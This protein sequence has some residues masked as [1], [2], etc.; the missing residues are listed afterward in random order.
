MRR[1]GQP[2]PHTL[3]WVGGNSPP[4][5]GSMWTPSPGHLASSSGLSYLTRSG[6]W[7]PWP[8]PLPDHFLSKSSLESWDVTL[9][10]MLSHLLSFMVTLF[11]QFFL[12]F[13]KCIII[14]F[15]NYLLILWLTVVSIINIIYFIVFIIIIYNVILVS[16]DQLSDLTILHLSRYS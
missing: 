15:I 4:S 14:Y 3:S 5:E 10:L 12:I 1:L 11:G 13:K 6:I 16:G 7:P 9:P 2:T 8:L